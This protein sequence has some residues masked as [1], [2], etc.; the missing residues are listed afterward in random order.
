MSRVRGKD[1]RPE[2]AVRRLIYAMGFRYRLHRRDIPG[3][4][5][6]VFVQ[7]RKLIF[8]HGCYW[9]RH[10]GCSNTR[11]PKSNVAFWRTK[12]LANRKR[13]LRNQRKLSS[14]GWLTLVIWECEVGNA[15]R[16]RRQVETF[17]RR[18]GR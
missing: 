12:L 10:P 8:V 17:L 16:L 7:A 18:G 5:D 11:L 14:L 2:L 4:P 13:D 3:I 9:H 6:L 1:T 15:T